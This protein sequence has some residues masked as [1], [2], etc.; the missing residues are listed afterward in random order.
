MNPFLHEEVREGVGP[1]LYYEGAFVQHSVSVDVIFWGKNY[2]KS[3][4]TSLRTAIL[5]FYTHLSGSEYQGILT[6]YFDA[7]SNITPNVTVSSFIDEREAS[8]ADTSVAGIEKELAYAIDQNG[9]SSGPDTQFVVVPAPGTSY[10]GGASYCGYHQYFEVEKTSEIYAYVPYP[11]DPPYE[12]C[13]LIDQ[14]S[15]P[16]RAETTALSHEYAEAATDPHVNG[17]GSPSLEEIADLCNEFAEPMDVELPSGAWVENLYDNHLDHCTHADLNPARVY[18]L[19]EPAQEIHTIEADLA[20]TVNPVGLET[21]YHFEYGTTKA[22][23]L[24]TP[25]VSAGSGRK[26][27]HV[28]QTI[29]GLSANKNYHYRVVVTNATGTNRGK[30]REFFAGTAPPPIVTTENPSSI[31]DSKATLNGTLNVNGSDA[32]YYFEYGPTLS[33]GTKIPIPSGYQ[34]AGGTIPRSQVV[35]SLFPETTYH[36]RF[37]AKNL[38]GTSYGEDRSFSTTAAPFSFGSAFGSEGS[39]TGK[40]NRPAGV[41]VDTFQN[42]W[43]VDREN[44]RVEHFSR[45]G[46]SIAFTFGAKGSGNSQFSRPQDVAVDKESHLWVTDSGNHR[47]QEFNLQG[48]YLGQFGS[49][50]GGSG[51]FSEPTGIATTLAG[52]IWVSDAVGNRLQEFTS[53]GVFIREV[54]GAGF[55][56]KGNGEFAQP[57]GLA[58]DPG[59]DIWV[60]DTGNNRVQELGPTGEFLTKFGSEGT[61]GAQFKQPY[62]VAVNNAGKLLVVDKNNSRVQVLSPSGELFGQFGAPGVGSGQ[63]TE[64]QSIALGRGG[65][66]FVTDTG[67]NR[68]ERWNQT[69]KPDVTTY[70]GASYSYEKPGE[71]S[72]SA[73]VYPGGLAT[74]YQIEYGPTTAYGSNIPVS[75]GSAGEGFEN[76]V[77]THTLTELPSNTRY[78]FR[79]TATNKDGTS[80]GV[81]SEFMTPYWSPVV[82]TAPT[83]KVGAKEATLNGTVN[84]GGSSTE[85]HFEYGKTTSYG[86]YV[87]GENVGSGFEVLSK[88]K[89]V[90]GLE[91]ETT[92]HYR[93]VATNS[94]GETSK[95]NDR[96][97]TTSHSFEFEFSSQGKL[98][99]GA[100][101]DSSGNVWVVDTESSQVVEFNSF[102][103]SLAVI[104]K[105]GSGNGQLS[106]PRGVAVAPSGIW[107]ADTGNHRI[108][109][110]GTKGEYLGQFGSEAQFAEPW[111]VAVGPNG[112]IWVTDR[113]GNKVEEF[114][115]GGTL[116]REQH[117]KEPGGVGD[118]EFLHPSGVATDS[119]ENV[120]V[121]DS[122][123]NR[124]QKLSPTAEYMSKFGGL[125]QL[126]EPS[127]IAVRSS[128]NLMVVDSGNNRV[129]SFTPS[130]AFVTTFGVEGSGKGAFVHPQ[131]IGVTAAGTIYV[132]DTGNGRV[133]IWR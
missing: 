111:G 101:V 20:A 97:F 36:Y 66:A 48:E 40:F 102:G 80:H 129:Q 105:P 45:T 107:V 37:V 76:V 106:S 54:H 125:G 113:K 117:G 127:G 60:A 109:R 11:G 99:T 126:L 5:N 13:K 122:G 4:G 18:G 23:G 133:E 15:D 98:P 69:G 63:F 9:W 77:K 49:A 6:Q 119:G 41:V 30:D 21:K 92:Y 7:T 57:Q 26:N 50:G 93:L 29:T 132:T 103:L 123:N 59:G 87:S 75:P 2:T 100:A 94:R 3:P 42:V 35:S 27:S 83:S 67:N 65:A 33:Y 28:A 34:T 81:D 25:E 96:T 74:S 90:T 62:D 44:N 85:I 95:G 84:P 89:V 19:T 70:G 114:S 128:G 116:L 86:T 10:P 121:V 88:S 79:T 12:G 56:G 52:N 43:V 108:E 16:I 32:N 24:Q 31:T 51:Q 112:F 46:E 73:G 120:W 82:T 78:H 14:V 71:I 131:G 22:Y 38:G 53:K 104:G 124:V 17:W 110:F 72:I 118:G 58:S 1:L 64:P 55:G 47:V 8:P 39:G 68:V 130:G 61:G 115:T 91:P